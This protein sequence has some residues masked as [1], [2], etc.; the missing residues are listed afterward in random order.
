MKKYEI[1]PNLFWIGLSLYIM[2]ASYNM[3]LVDKASLALEKVY[4]PGPGLM[5]FFS[6]FLLL[7]LSGYL[8]TSTFLKGV[9]VEPQEV[10]NEAHAKRHFSRPI[11][12]LPVLF[13]YALVLEPL[14]YLVTTCL[15][16]LI[17][18][19]M[20]NI[21]WRYSLFASLTTTLVTYFGFTYLGLLLPDGIIK[22]QRF[23]L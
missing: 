5:P 14:G 1:I 7:L 17:L 3:G 6:A 9:Q 15:A 16:L 23:L 4:S 12:V 22:L 19:K 18:F 2:L 20:M 11:L 8:L 10:K 13:G 21:K